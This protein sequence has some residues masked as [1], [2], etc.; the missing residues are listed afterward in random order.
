M[1]ILMITLAAFSVALMGPARAAND[2]DLTGLI[3]PGLWKATTTIEVNGQQK[4]RSHQ[5][6]VT[7]SQVAHFKDSLKNTMSKAGGTAKIKTFKRDGRKLHMI[8]AFSTGMVKVNMDSH[9]VF[10]TPTAYHG[11]THMTMTGAHE[12][13]RDMKVKAHRV[14]QCTQADKD[15]QGSKK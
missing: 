4:T 8:V 9:Y 12:M 13:T 1:K 6:C 7:K 10:T 2:G 5:K 15:T 3:K 14:G 11:K